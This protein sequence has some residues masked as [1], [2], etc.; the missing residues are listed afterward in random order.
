M[1]RLLVSGSGPILDFY[2]TGLVPRVPRAI[3][4][5]GLGTLSAVSLAIG[6]ILD[7]IAKLH[8]ETIELWKRHLRSG[9]PRP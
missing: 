2:R 6:L 9:G 5:A 1:K 3:L 8:D 4:A 7:T